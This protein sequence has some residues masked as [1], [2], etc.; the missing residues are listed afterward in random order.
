VQKIIAQEIA[1]A[2]YVVTVP[3]DSRAV[4]VYAYGQP[5]YYSIGEAYR[6]KAYIRDVIREELRALVSG[7][8][9]Q[10][11]APRPQ[12]TNQPQQ[13]NKPQSLAPDTATPLELQQQVIAAYQGRANCLGCHGASGRASGPN[14]TEFRLVLDDGSGG[15]VLARHSSDKRWKI[16]GMASS[17]TMPPTAAN[18][19]S[20]AME[21]K[22]L[23]TLLQYALS[24]G[25]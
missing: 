24:K 11:T 12:S 25:E 13:P 16:Y 7:N 19:A 2:P 18:D 9:P 22:H 14:G 20:K 6:E 1:V 15:L 3:V 17:G 4:P 10:P 21:P 5:Y 8:V 23:A